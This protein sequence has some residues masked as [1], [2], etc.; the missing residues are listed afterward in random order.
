MKMLRFDTYF[1]QE[2]VDT[3]YSQLRTFFL[4]LMESIVTYFDKTIGQT[5]DAIKEAETNLKKVKKRRI[6]S[7]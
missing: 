6:S 1:N 5:D 4:I 3:W 7:Y 2:F